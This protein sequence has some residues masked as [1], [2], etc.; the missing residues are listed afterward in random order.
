MAYRLVVGNTI[1]FT[2]RF[3]LNDAGVERLFGI[4]LRAQRQPADE[5]QTKLQASGVSMEQFLRRPELGL[6]MVDWVGD[7]ALID[8]AGAP[9]PAGDEALD[10]LL[11]T[12]A[13]LPMVAFGAYA[14]A[15]GAKAKLGN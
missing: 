6:Q 12:V 7:P 3:E 1:E 11:R 13:N 15:G 4:R 9:A 2:V 10:H 8:D 14:E 5:L